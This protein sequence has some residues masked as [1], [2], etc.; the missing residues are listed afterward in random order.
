MLFFYLATLLQDMQFYILKCGRHENNFGNE[1][2]CCPLQ[3]R[4]CR[5]C[6]KPYNINAPTLL[7]KQNISWGGGGKGQLLKVLTFIL[8]AAIIF[9][10]LHYC[11]LN[12]PNLCFF[13]SLPLS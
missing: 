10:A 4:A 5:I 6:R 3:L 2:D 7:L 8:V 11:S 13:C 12:Q 9:T 1:E